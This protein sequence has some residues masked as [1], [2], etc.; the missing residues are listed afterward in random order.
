MRA[1][2]AKT[3][4]SPRSSAPAAW[5][6][7]PHDENVGELATSELGVVIARHRG[8]HSQ[9]ALAARHADAIEILAQRHGVFAR[10]AEQ[11]ADL[12]HRQ[13]ACRSASRSRTNAPHLGFD[14]DMQINIL[15]NVH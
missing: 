3:C 5:S 14:V 8:Q 2:V 15:R 11:I 12:R 6:P 4:S 13:P 7:T 10:R 1:N 9:V